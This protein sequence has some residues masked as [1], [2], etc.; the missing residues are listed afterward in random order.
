MAL[1]AILF[2]WKFRKYDEREDEMNKANVHEE[3]SSLED[4]QNHRN[5]QE[6]P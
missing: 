6:L 3:D 4:R 1:S 2:W 5:D